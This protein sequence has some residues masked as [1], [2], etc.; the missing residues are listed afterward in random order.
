MVFVNVAE[1]LFPKTNLI[2]GDWNI[3]LANCNQALNRPLNCRES[4][5]LVTLLS[6]IDATKFVNGFVI[7]F[8]NILISLTIAIVANPVLIKS[9]YLMNHFSI[10]QTGLYFCNEK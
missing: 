6:I 5:R 9:M 1:T 2:G 3:V 8:L 10:S 7:V 4:H